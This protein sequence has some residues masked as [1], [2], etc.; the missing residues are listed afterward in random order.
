MNIHIYIYINP[1]VNPSFSPWVFTG[2]SF[3]PS[4]DPRLLRSFGSFPAVV[5]HGGAGCR[6]FC[7]AVDVSKLFEPVVAPQIL[8][9]SPIMFG[10]LLPRYMSCSQSELVCSLLIR[11]KMAENIALD[12]ECLSRLPQV[13]RRKVTSPHQS[14]KAGTLGHPKEVQHQSL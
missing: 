4:R 7:G 9:A 13:T 11:Q 5:A 14:I 2:N 1:S 10:V 3:R 12:V 6:G 8:V